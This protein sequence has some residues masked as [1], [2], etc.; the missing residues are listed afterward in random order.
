M[1]AELLHVIL[2]GAFF[3]VVVPAVCIVVV[4]T[5]ARVRVA[6]VA[7]AMVLSGIVAYRWGHFVGRDKSSIAARGNLVLPFAAFCRHAAKLNARGETKRLSSSLARVQ[8]VLDQLPAHWRE[9]LWEQ[10]SLL[11][12]VQAETAPSPPHP[13]T[14]AG[15]R[16]EE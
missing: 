5:K 3:L 1:P 10:T 2:I 13:S 8:E 4:K 14:G 9:P 7:V 15:R 12:A 16:Q 6:V 11:K